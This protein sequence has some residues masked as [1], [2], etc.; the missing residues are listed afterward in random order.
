VRSDFERKPTTEWNAQ[1]QVVR[2]SLF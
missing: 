1:W 2:E